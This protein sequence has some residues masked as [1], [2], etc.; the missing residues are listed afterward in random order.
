MIASLTV[1][2][3]LELPLPQ[4]KDGVAVGDGLAGSVMMEIVALPWALQPQPLRA[5]K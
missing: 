5:R 4:I 3:K 1:A 2:D